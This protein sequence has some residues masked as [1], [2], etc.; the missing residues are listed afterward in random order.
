[1][2]IK[3]IKENDNFNI[4]IT[5]NLEDIRILRNTMES[6][7]SDMRVDEFK[8]MSVNICLMEAIY[9]GMLHS[10]KGE[11]NQKKNLD[12]KINKFK[13][14]IKIIIQDH[15]K[16]EWLKKY[17]LPQLEDIAD[18]PTHGMGLILMQNLSDNMQINSSKHGTKVIMKINIE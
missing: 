16:K 11:S 18:H 2:G 1:M 15:G 12:I 10:Y 5:K 6:W 8:I 7:L 9:N 3:I 13:N 17:K 4:V 14:S